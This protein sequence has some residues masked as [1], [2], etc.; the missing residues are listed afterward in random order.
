[1]RIRFLGGAREV[2]ASCV[3][4]TSASG[5]NIL[6]DCG[7]RVNEEGTEMLPDLEPL[8]DLRV[9]AVIISHAHLDHSGALPLV[10]KV[11]PGAGVPGTGGVYAHATAATKDLARV[12]LYDAIKVAEFRE[13]L[14]LYDEA[15]AERALDS[16][17]THG[18]HEPFDVADGVRAKFLPAG[19]ILGAASVLLQFE[20][21]TL[22]YTGDFTTFDQETVGMQ[23]FTPALK[24]GVDV[25][26]TEATYGSRLHASRTQEVER[27]LDAI[28]ETVAAG[29]KVLIPAFAV[30]RAQEIIL[31]LRNHLRRTKKKI[32]VYVDG[33]VRNVNAVFAANVDYLAPRYN[34]EVLRGYE[35]FYT[36][37][38]E[39]VDSKAKRDGVLAS[40]G[41]FVAIASSGML[42]GGVSPIYAERIVGDE[43]NLLAIV[44]YQDEESPGR[45]LLELSEKPPGER[46][47]TLN[48]A[49]L[50]V[51]CKIGKYGLSAHADSL[52]IVLSVKALRPEFVLVNHG[53]DESCAALATF[54]ASEMPGAR[55]EVAVRGREYEYTPRPNAARKYSMSP[56]IR[57]ISL[58]RDE[59]LRPEELWRHLVANG[60][61]GTT[62]TVKDLIAA[63]YGGRDLP[64]EEM[65]AAG[66][67]VRSDAH[68]RA[69]T[70]NPNTIYVLTETE[71]VEATTPHPLEQNAARA[72]VQ[73]RLSP[74]GLQRIGFAGDGT[75]TLYFPT[76]KYAERC[77]DLIAQLEKET[78]RRV[79]V[80]QSVNTQ[81]L[82]ERVKFDLSSRFGMLP[83]KDPSI[84]ADGAMTVTLPC[85]KETSFGELD[86]LKDDL[87]E[88]AAA[89]EGETGMGIS[90]KWSGARPG[91]H[92]SCGLLPE[93]APGRAAERAAELAPGLAPGP[94]LATA[95]GMASSSEPFEAEAGDGAST[96]IPIPSPAPAPDPD[97]A[98]AHHLPPHALAAGETPRAL[99]QNVAKRL[100]DEAFRDKPHKPKVSIYPHERRMGLSFISPQVGARY[101]AL[102]SDLE[103]TT[104]WRL[105]V[106]GTVRVN[107]IV[108]V[109]RQLLASRGLK[110]MKVSAYDGYVEA[111]GPDAVAVDGEMLRSL[112][113]E[114]RELTGFDLR[115]RRT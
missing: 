47:L 25:V 99:E 49:D 5:R 37:G 114:Y 100:I 109:A 27:L 87:R 17:L 95:L 12:L 18:Y 58:Y 110:G 1:M 97:R 112:Y 39:A 9:D 81:F 88:Y 82:K 78:L 30:G 8:R 24:R 75:I 52:G 13:G 42:T 84:G 89:F 33:L 44:G 111:K 21:G 32:P 115:F 20:E 15:D 66:E 28:T 53:N 76:P 2:G 105:D 102:L 56:R 35:L 69:S 72:L 94:A 51:N 6:L 4:V 26:V 50:E 19:H 74:F 68:F 91:P 67:A 63:W 101:A 71:Y 70:T 80:A 40:N 83:E 43:R 77:R 23:K 64:E 103:R 48:D 104:G 41:P 3:L 62:S 92:G 60:L 85:S 11:L 86:K 29:G 73:E 54:L 46:R 96:P 59:A 31:A 79:E 45:R 57:A 7:V 14:K 107:E 16:T 55:I 106:L 38:I 98:P 65:K 93:P 34:R 90:F 10:M 108:E 113:E 36:N 22:L 61:A